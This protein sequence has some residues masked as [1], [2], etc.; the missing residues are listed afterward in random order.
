[1]YIWICETEVDKRSE[2][3]C[4]LFLALPC[5]TKL[6]AK[7]HGWSS[8]QKSG[9]RRNIQKQMAYLYFARVLKDILILQQ[10]EKNEI[11]EAL[12]K[13]DKN[14]GIREAIQ[15]I[16]DKRIAN[17][18]KYIQE[19]K[20]SNKQKLLSFIE[21]YNTTYL[22]YKDNALFTYLHSLKSDIYDEVYTFL[23]YLV[24]NG[25]SHSCDRTKMGYS[26]DF[27]QDRTKVLK[28]VVN[29]LLP[30]A[31][32]HVRREERFDGKKVYD[33]TVIWPVESGLP[34]Y[35]KILFCS[36]HSQG[37]NYNEETW[38]FEFNEEEFEAIDYGKDYDR[39]FPPVI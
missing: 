30:E 20:E 31:E 14:K 36:N 29:L 1:M 22:K 2:G 11:L 13:E 26:Q 12:S 15:K 17:R 25:R 38:M 6:I 21:Q 24:H 4:P 16:E 28:T 9:Q 39:R 35:A 23:F 32:F 8:C 5:L 33:C 10:D 27:I 18:P 37:M 3:P 7:F 19:Q 34:D